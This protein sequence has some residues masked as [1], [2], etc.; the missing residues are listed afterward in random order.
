MADKALRYLDALQAKHPALA[1][2]VGQ[3]A[4]LYRRKLWH[5]ARPRGLLQQRSAWPE[6][7]CPRAPHRSLHLARRAGPSSG[8][9]LRAER[10]RRA[11]DGGAGGLPGAA[12]A[13]AGGRAAADL[14]QL[15]GQL[16]AQAQPAAAGAA[17]GDRRAAGL[18]RAAAAPGGWRAHSLPPLSAPPAGGVRSRPGAGLRARGRCA[19]VR[20]AWR[21]HAVRQGVRAR[22]QLRFWRASRPRWRRRSSRAWSSRRCTCACTWRSTS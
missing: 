19:R 9:P 4:D 14:P 2:C 8:V 1:P 11:A 21:L 5:Q 20:A 7:D 13:A 12:G 10:R 18:C 16:R 17:G 6:P 22:G 15:R 3:L